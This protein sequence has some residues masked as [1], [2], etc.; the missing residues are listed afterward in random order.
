MYAEQQ[1]DAITDTVVL[2]TNH[3]PYKTSRQ[4]VEDGLGPC[5]KSTVQAYLC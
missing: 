2:Q 5:W 1:H 3:P 4:A